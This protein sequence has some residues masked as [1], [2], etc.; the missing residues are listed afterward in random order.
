MMKGDDVHQN[1]WRLGRVTGTTTDKDEL[2]R[3]VKI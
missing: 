3:R 2:V 1:E